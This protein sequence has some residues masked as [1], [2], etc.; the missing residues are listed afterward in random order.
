V[1]GIEFYLVFLLN[2]NFFNVNYY[3]LVFLYFDMVMLKINF[4]K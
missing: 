4:K 2:F 1:F 3:F